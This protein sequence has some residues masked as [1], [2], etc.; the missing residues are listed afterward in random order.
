[1]VAPVALVVQKG[2]KGLPLGGRRRVGGRLSSSMC[3]Q[4]P[5]SNV[6]SGEGAVSGPPPVDV[7]APTSA[8]MCTLCAPLAAAR[9]T[10]GAS[11]RTPGGPR[12]H[13]SRRAASSSPAPP[14]AVDPCRP[15]CRRSS[16]GRVATARASSLVAPSDHRRDCHCAGRPLRT[17]FSA[18]PPCLAERTLSSRT[19]A[20]WAPSFDGGAGWTLGGTGR[21]GAAI[22]AGR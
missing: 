17:V 11:H 10:S 19:C 8:R 16:F 2:Q 22:V 21:C 12:S 7:G 4:R 13:P 15:P 9:R 1:L 14:P 18:A 20:W 3:H 6:A 5:P